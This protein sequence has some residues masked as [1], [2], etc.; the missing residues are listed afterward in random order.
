MYINGWPI[1][2]IAVISDFS[3]SPPTSI[4]DASNTA[5]GSAIGMSVILE[6]I[7]NSKIISMSKPLPIKSSIYF[8]RNCINKINITTEKLRKKGRRNDVK[9]NFWNMFTLIS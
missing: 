6:Y 8:Q 9:I 5:S 1:E 7:S 2:L 4:I 3:A